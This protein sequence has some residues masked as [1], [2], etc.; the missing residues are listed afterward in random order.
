[1]LSTGEPH[2]SMDFSLPTIFSKPK[3]PSHSASDRSPQIV[4]QN[5]FKFVTGISRLAL[6]LP[7]VRAVIAFVYYLFLL[8]DLLTG[9]R[10]QSSDYENKADAITSCRPPTP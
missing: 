8:T 2:A 9:R 10:H 4:H 1:M 5:P 7:L 6:G 3:I